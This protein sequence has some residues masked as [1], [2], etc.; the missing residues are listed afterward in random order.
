MSRTYV[1]I[2]KQGQ[3][4]RQARQGGALACHFP[5]SLHALND[6][7]MEADYHGKRR[8]TWFLLKEGEVIE[9]IHRV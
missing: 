9:N 1:Q 4:S 6:N 8:I 7:K 3:A 5:A 2:I